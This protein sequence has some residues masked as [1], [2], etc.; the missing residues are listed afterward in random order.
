MLGYTVYQF[1][2]VLVGLIFVRAIMS[3]VVK[4]RS[5]QIV[6]VVFELT[7]PILKPFREVLSKVGIGGTIDISPLIAIMVLQYVGRLA[8]IWLR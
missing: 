8:Y 3:W 7:E 2:R 5:N 6:K 1:M 4:D